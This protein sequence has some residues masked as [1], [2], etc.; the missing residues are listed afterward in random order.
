MW[1]NDAFCEE[2]KGSEQ[3]VLSTKQ[4]KILSAKKE[5]YVENTEELKLGQANPNGM[6]AAAIALT[7]EKKPLEKKL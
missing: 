5:A 7:R 2:Q 6:K 4:S 3:K 1:L